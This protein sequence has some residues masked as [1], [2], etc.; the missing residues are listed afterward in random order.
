[1]RRGPNIQFTYVPQTS[2]FFHKNPVSLSDI[3]YH[4][5]LEFVKDYF[6]YCDDDEEEESANKWTSGFLLPVLHMEA[7]NF[8]CLSEI[9][10]LSL[11]LSSGAFMGI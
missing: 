7:E 9:L 10:Y 8:L 1:M 2:K 11:D 5:S 3:F 6:N 4:L